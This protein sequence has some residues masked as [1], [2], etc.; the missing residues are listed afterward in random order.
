MISEGEGRL[1]SEGEVRGVDLIR[2]ERSR[3]G[4]QRQTKMFLENF[5]TFLWELIYLKNKF[6]Y[7]F[8]DLF[9]F[10]MKTKQ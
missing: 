5:F 6:L 1:L 4:L 9:R 8:N 10:S 7:F 2:E 3:R